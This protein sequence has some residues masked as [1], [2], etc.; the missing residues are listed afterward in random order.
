MKNIWILAE[1]AEGKVHDSSLEVLSEGL[2]LA[3]EI[4]GQVNVVAA[5]SNS[6]EIAEVLGTCA[7]DKVYF[8]YSPTLDEYHIER[9]VEVLSQF[10]EAERPEIILLSATLTGRDI[11]ARLAARLKTGLISDCIS[12]SLNPEGLLSGTKLTYGGKVSSTI[13][14]PD[15]RPQMAT[16]KPGIAS[17]SKPDTSRK[18]VVSVIK[19]EVNLKESGIN[20][21]GVVKADPENISL[22]EAEVIVAGGRGVANQENFQFLEEIAKRL[23]GVVAASLGAIDEGWLPHKKLI[24]QTGTTVAP[25]LYIACGISGSIYHVLGMRDSEFV[26]AINKD[27]NAPIFKV[28][29]MSII[30]DTADIL[31]AIIDRLPV[32]N[33][34]TTTGQ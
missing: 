4:D 8:L 24:G 5:G 34:N 7:A 22:D 23:G 30:G 19:P 33:Q 6:Q 17:I 12:L 2:K 18:T 13:I 14:C 1:H 31:S 10:F 27:P 26:I 11:A 32:V 3:G 25:K 15:S 29:D 28:A 16:L 9:Y 20:V 21:K